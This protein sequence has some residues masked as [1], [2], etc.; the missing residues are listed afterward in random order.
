MGSIEI[1]KLNLILAIYHGLSTEVLEKGVGHV[2]GT[3]LPIGGASTHACWRDTGDFRVQRFLR[4]LT[5]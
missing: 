2:E 5:R 3:S 4:I 1:P